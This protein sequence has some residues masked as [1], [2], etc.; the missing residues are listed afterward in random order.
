MFLSWNRETN[1]GGLSFKVG[2]NAS[3]AETSLEL[4]SISMQSIETILTFR[5]GFEWPLYTSV[6]G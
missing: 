3:E 2:S 4:T 5:Q 1:S 6:C